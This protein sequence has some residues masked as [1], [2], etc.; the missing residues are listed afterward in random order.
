[1]TAYVYHG[2]GLNRGTIGV[3][4]QARAAGLVGNPRTFWR[5][6][7]D[8]ALGR[9]FDQLVREPTAEILAAHACVLRYYAALMERRGQPLR[10]LNLTHRQSA[11]KGSDP[12]Q[13]IASNAAAVADE[14]GYTED[15]TGRTWGR[16]LAQRP[17]WY[18]PFFG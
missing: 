18:E 1:M 15:M 10:S 16:G 12:G 13:A 9:S 4:V 8:K 2:H 5:S 3:E 11:R 6:R 7:R 17:Q 14:L